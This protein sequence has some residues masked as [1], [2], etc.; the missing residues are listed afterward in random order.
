[1]S[2]VDDG[3][4]GGARAIKS[5]RTL[6]AISSEGSFRAAADKIGV[7]PAAV[8]QQM[9]ALE[10][11]FWGVAFQPGRPGA[12]PEHKRQRVDPKSKSSCGGV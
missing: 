6:I 3:A 12:A 4:R 1:M 11:Q 8:G 9:K 7:S 2:S 10:A 5:L